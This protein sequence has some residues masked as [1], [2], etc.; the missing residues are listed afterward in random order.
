M[1]LQE[2]NYKTYWNTSKAWI[3]GKV[4]YGKERRCKDANS[5]QINLLIL[6]D[7]NQNAN[8]ASHGTSATSKIHKEEW[9]SKNSEGNSRKEEQVRGVVYLKRWE[10]YD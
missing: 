8:R 1:T 5:P 4:H 3:N 7:S 6:Y 10:S 9:N 2:E